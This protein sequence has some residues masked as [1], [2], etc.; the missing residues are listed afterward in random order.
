MSENFGFQN[1]A[2]SCHAISDRPNLE[3]V[4]IVLRRSSTGGPPLS[5]IAGAV[6]PNPRSSVA[7]TGACEPD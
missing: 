7:P 4:R 3:K 6:R 1:R 5:L 2:R